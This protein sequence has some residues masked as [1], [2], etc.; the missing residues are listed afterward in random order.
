[1]N[2]DI[3]NF[4]KELMFDDGEIETLL[5]AVPVLNETPFEK[6]FANMTAV[7]SAGYPVEEIGHIISQN[8]AFLCR[9]TAELQ[10]NLTKIAENGDIVDQLNND[11][12]LI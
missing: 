12:N 9:N 5:R 10:Q 1:M 4:L 7:V 11:P 6:A 3:Y 2:Q 8:P